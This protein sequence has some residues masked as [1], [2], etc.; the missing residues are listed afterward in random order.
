MFVTAEASLVISTFYF[1]IT[2]GPWR[3]E[4]LR[5]LATLTE[6]LSLISSTLMVAHNH[7]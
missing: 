7:Q 6:D 2:C 5:A 4:Q 3:D 1:N